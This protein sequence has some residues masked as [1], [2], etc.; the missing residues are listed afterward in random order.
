MFAAVFAGACL[1]F[2]DEKFEEGTLN[3][4]TVATVSGI[5]SA[6]VV[7]MVVLLKIWIARDP[8]GRL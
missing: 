2:C 5:L 7:I 8:G 3:D 1:D 4:H 6:T